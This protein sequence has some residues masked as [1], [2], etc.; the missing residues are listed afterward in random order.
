[1]GGLKEGKKLKRKMQFKVYR[2]M[3]G[4]YWIVPKA[5]RLSRS[6]FGCAED[7]ACPDKGEPVVVCSTWLHRVSS[8][9]LKPGGGP[10]ESTID[11]RKAK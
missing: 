6:V 8:I 1:M 3:N 9:R 11:I 4:T 5:W 7:W 10:V 2:R